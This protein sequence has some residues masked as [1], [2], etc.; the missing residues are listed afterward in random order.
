[1]AY[2]GSLGALV[3]V[4]CSAAV[5]LG[6][7][8]PARD[9]VTLGG[10]VSTQVGP[11]VRREWG[12]RLPRVS[13][14]AQIANIQAF[15]HG[16]FGRGP[17]VFV[18]EIA[19]T[20]NMVTPQG[21]VFEDLGTPQGGTSA[22]G[23]PLVLSDGR[24]S[25]RS[26]VV[27]SPSTQVFLP[28]VDGVYEYVPVI[29]GQRVSGSIWA[30]GSSPRLRMRF[31]DASLSLLSTV[32]GSPAVGAGPQVLTVE[33]AIVPEGAVAVLLVVDGV[34]RVA[35]P[36]ISWTSRAQGWAIGDGA[37]MV[38]VAEVSQAPEL[39]LDARQYIDASFVVREVG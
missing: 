38:H 10:R 35:R 15:V 21:S 11:R 24:R 33:G 32:T 27:E 1:M 18:S 36:S 8:R 19:M 34:S 16:E 14:P 2:L 13:T 3:D 23:G 12:L 5:D 29:S 30:Q 25:G 9:V 7:G 20:T 4:G 39:L 22:N 6:A 37:P 31:Y 26:L 28:R 17:W